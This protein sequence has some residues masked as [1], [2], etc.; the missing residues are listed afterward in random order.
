M[1]AAASLHALES[2]VGQETGAFAKALDKFNDTERGPRLKRVVELLTEAK[3]AASEGEE[4]RA[5][6]RSLVNN[7]DAIDLKSAPRSS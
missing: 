2:S 1:G 7:T 4:A 6:A 3:P 5:Q